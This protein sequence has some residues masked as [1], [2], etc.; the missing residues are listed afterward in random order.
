M[1]TALGIVFSCT[2]CYS[3]DTRNPKDLCDKG[4]I[5]LCPYWRISQLLGGGACGREFT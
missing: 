2:W 3:L 1:F 4:L 5:A